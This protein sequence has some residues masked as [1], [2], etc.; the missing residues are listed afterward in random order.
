MNLSN[1]VFDFRLYFDFVL[2]NDFVGSGNLCS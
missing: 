2:L 1:E